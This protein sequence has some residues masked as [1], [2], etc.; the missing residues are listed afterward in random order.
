MLFLRMRSIH[1]Q[2]FSDAIKEHS[3]DEA[4][5]EQ[6]GY[7]SDEEVDM[8]DEEEPEVE[9]SI[10]ED[11]QRFEQSFQGISERFRIINRI[12]EGMVRLPDPS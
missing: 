2:T 8:S 6:E 12:G 3:G 5:H 1:E 7:Y 4:S 11:I 10:Q 9:E